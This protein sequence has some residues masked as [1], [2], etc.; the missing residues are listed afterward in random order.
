MLR[1]RPAVWLGERADKPDAEKQRTGLL[2]QLETLKL[3]YAG[4]VA[5]AMQNDF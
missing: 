3:Q 1:N 2:E 4:E 5:Y